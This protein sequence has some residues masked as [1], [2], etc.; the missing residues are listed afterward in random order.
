MPLDKAL[1]G[2]RFTCYECGAKFY[3]MNKP[4][5]ICPS[6]GADQANDPNPDP[7]E[8]LKASKRSRRS[9]TKA[10]SVDESSVETPNLDDSEDG[11]DVDD[12]DD[13]MGD[14]DE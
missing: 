9:K 3:D 11:L 4:E 12:D 2:T 7:I 13:D 14:D 8:M 10:S 5:A 1:L 6:C